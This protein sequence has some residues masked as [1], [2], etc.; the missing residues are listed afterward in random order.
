M[1][2][3]KGNMIRS[4]AMIVGAVSLLACSS[5][6]EPAGNDAQGRHPVTETS[7]LMRVLDNVPVTGSLE[8]VST[9][10]LRIPIKG[11]LSG[12][13][14]MLLGEVNEVAIVPEGAQVKLQVSDQGHVRLEAKPHI[15]KVK[16]FTMRDIT[17]TTKPYDNNHAD[18]FVV[19]G[20]RDPNSFIV[21]KLMSMALGKD[22]RNKIKAAIRGFDRAVSSQPDLGSLTQL[23]T[24]SGEG[25]QQSLLNPANMRDFVVTLSFKQRHRRSVHTEKISFDLTGYGMIDVQLR[26]SGPLT[27]PRFE[28]ASVDPRVNGSLRVGKNETGLFG[29]LKKVAL[30]RIELTKGRHM[31]ATYEFV[32]VIDGITDGIQTTFYQRKANGYADP[33]TKGA[34]PLQKKAPFNP[35]TMVEKEML[36]LVLDMEKFVLANDA[37]IPGHSLNALLDGS[38]V[39]V[40]SLGF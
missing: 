22:I 14:G 25:V 16:N 13:P 21:G 24:T 36:D 17:F 5:S 32:A 28:S 2:R 6:E 11:K 1:K 29:N 38:A 4:C 8:F 12:L 39:S 34:R 31:K 26:T 23:L 20:G 18:E 30:H 27:A 19:N 40:E 33:V 37:V 9:R 10:E 3:A 7:Q 15:A 35:T